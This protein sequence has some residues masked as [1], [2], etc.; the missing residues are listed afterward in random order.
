MLYKLADQLAQAL[1]RPFLID[2]GY[3]ADPARRRARHDRRWSRTIVG[4]FVG[5]WVTTLA[6]LGHS[7]WI[8]GFLQVFSNVGYYLLSI[9]DAPNLAAMYAATGF[10]LLHLG[11]GHRRLLAC[12]CCG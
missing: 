2:M 6:G 4:A 12:C 3:N 1:T 7:L 8:F 9:L 5:G 11:H 10:E